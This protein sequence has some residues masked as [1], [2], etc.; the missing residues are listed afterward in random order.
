MYTLPFVRSERSTRQSGYRRKISRALSQ[1]EVSPLWIPAEHRLIYRSRKILVSTM[2][3]RYNPSS[4]ACSCTSNGNTRVFE[5]GI[6]SSTP[7]LSM[8]KYNAAPHSRHGFSTL[9]MSLLEKVN[10]FSRMV[11]TLSQCSQWISSRHIV[12]LSSPNL[13]A[14]FRRELGVCGRSRPTYDPDIRTAQPNN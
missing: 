3:C 4:L 1:S 9:P 6:Y 5:Y 7:L 14:S 12:L 13:I 11:A 10:L 2:S 8:H